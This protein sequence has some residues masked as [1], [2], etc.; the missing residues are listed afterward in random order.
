MRSLVSAAC[1]AVLSLC[2]HVTATADDQAVAV[3]A[4]DPG[5]NAAPGY[6]DP[7]AALGGPTR[8][9]GVGVFPGVVS[10]FNPPY[11]PGEIVSIG[12]GGSLTVE[13]GR[14]ALDDPANPFGI[15]LLIFANAFFIDEAFPAGVAGPLFGATG[16]VEVSPN[17]T[18]WTTLPGANPGG[19]FPTRGYQDSGPF[20]TL[21]GRIETDAHMP[22]DPAISPGDVQGFSFAAL[23]EVYGTSAGGL[24]IDLATAGLSAVR[25]VRI[26][27]PEEA[28]S[29][30]AI[31][32]ITIVRPA[33]PG[34]LN[35]DGL[36]NSA[37]LLIL[38]STWGPCPAPG[39]CP[40]DLN[41]DGAVDSAD[42]LFLISHWS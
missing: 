24:G 1:A 23:S 22:V 13:L 9:T 26:S 39:A 42:L 5:R 40:A 21:P 10:P 34:D 6:T 14:D 32:A 4:Y 18:D 12:A 31:D 37:D 17:G 16:M 15:D 28:T 3:I 36:V 8:F 29:P 41:G 7:G 2:P 11:M 38:L 19:G 27:V 35:G 30:L 20:D 25:F 33:V